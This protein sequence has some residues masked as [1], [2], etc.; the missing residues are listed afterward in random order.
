MHVPEYRRLGAEIRKQ[1]N[2]CIVTGVPKIYGAPV[3]ATDLRA[4]AGLILMGLAAEGET[5]VLKISHIDRGYERLE[6]KLTSL[7]AKIER[8]Q[9]MPRRRA[10]DRESDRPMAA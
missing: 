8:V 6:D 4:G 3:A 10:S 5:E 9:Y 1:F 7:G 2:T